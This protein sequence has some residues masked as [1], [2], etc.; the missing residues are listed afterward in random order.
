MSSFR[1]KSL[2]SGVF[3]LEL[4]TAMRP[5][6]VNPEMITPGGSDEEKIL[7][8]KYAISV[9]RKLGAAVFLTYEDIVEVKPKMMLTFIGCLMAAD[10]GTG[11][12]ARKLSVLEGDGAAAAAE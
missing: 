7:N 1:D 12:V 11:P 4:L 2:A 6:T 5:Q 9:A 10:G 8:A 3:L